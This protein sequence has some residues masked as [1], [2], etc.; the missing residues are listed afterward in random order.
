MRSCGLR[1]IDE[2]LGNAIE[3][4]DKG[5]LSGSMRILRTVILMSLKL[6]LSFLGIDAP[7]DNALSLY[8][9]I[10]AEL[11][12]PVGER[13]LEDFEFKYRLAVD[14]EGPFDP[15]FVEAGFDIVERVV[16]WSKGAIKRIATEEKKL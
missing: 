9:L 8:Y 12:P 5:D 16:F 3:L 10:P 6:V 15:K 14:S 13:E 7:L 4:R 1:E 2:L 11:R